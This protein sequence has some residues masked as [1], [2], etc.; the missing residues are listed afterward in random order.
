MVQC[1]DEG[2]CECCETGA[3]DVSRHRSMIGPLAR[4]RSKCHKLS[5]VLFMACSLRLAHAVIP[6]LVGRDGVHLCYGSAM[7]CHANELDN[8]TCMTRFLRFL[9]SQCL[10]GLD[11]AR[12][13]ASS[14]VIV[15]TGVC[16]EAQQLSGPSR[17]AP[18]SFV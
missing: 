15:D 18:C 8:Y 3:T 16:S 13:A 5:I 11:V 10:L 14:P 1:S 6:V 4:L 2:R 12:A 17:P 9:F 7:W